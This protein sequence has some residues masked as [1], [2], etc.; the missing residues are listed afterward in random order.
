MPFDVRVN[1]GEGHWDTHTAPTRNEQDHLKPKR[2][3]IMLTV[4]RRMPQGMFPPALVSQRAIPDEIEDAISRR[5]KRTER[6]GR[7][8]AHHG[9]RIPLARPHHPQRRPIFQRGRQV[10]LEP[11]ESLCPD[12]E[13]TL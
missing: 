5:R 6:G 7:H 11:L 4:A 1:R 12:R 8:C 2:I 9:L 3:R 13:S 10:R